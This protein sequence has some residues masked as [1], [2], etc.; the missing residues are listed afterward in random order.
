MS[1]L[2]VTSPSSSSS[3]F[4][5]SSSLCSFD[6]LKPLSTK[7]RLQNVLKRLNKRKSYK[8]S[9]SPRYNENSLLKMS[10][11]IMKL[12]GKR[13]QK[14][15]EIRRQHVASQH[16]QNPNYISF[17]NEV[18]MLMGAN[19]LIYTHREGTEQ[20]MV[21]SLIRIQNFLM[22]E[23][24]FISCI[25]V[26]K[27]KNFLHYV[28][29]PEIQF[30]TLHLFEIMV[31]PL[32]PM[33]Y[34]VVSDIMRVTRS[35]SHVSVCEKAVNVLDVMAASNPQVRSSLYG[36]GV[37]ASLCLLINDFYEDDSRV[38][39]IRNATSC[40]STMCQGMASTNRAYVKDIFSTMS[41]V[42]ADCVYD[43]TTVFKACFVLTLL[44]ADTNGPLQIEMA[45]TATTLLAKILCLINECCDRSTMMSLLSLCEAII[46]YTDIEIAYIEKLKDALTSIYGRSSPCAQHVQEENEN[47][48]VRII[49][50]ENRLLRREANSNTITTKNYLQFS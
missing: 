41:L 8:G 12:R 5:S 29:F 38:G 44:L 20:A 37:M 14:F 40:I 3:L 47:M 18:E 4:Q 35:R 50:L 17:M 27:V 45:Q 46:P 31:N 6:P 30:N 33:C 1:I 48:W 7:E 11:E 36:K 13:A 28:I 19:T 26:A 49:A 10:I 32:N 34:D 9:G 25:D 15:L 21:D 22:N 16:Q 42:L 23:P 39:V 2:C 24:D 43:V